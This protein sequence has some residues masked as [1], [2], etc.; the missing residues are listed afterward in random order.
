MSG[1]YPIWNEYPHNGLDRSPLY[2]IRPL[3]ANTHEVE[4]IISYFMRLANSHFLNLGTL[5]SKEIFPRL[6]RKYLTDSTIKGSSK[7]YDDAGLLLGSG[8]LAKDFVAILEHLTGTSLLHL[9]TLMNLKDAFSVRGMLKRTKAWC[10]VCYQ[11]WAYLGKDI[12]DPLIWSFQSST[13]CNKHHVPLQAVCE[14]CEC[15]PNHLSRQAKPGHCPR[16][17]RWL[18]KYVAPSKIPESQAWIVENVGEL[19][20]LSSDCSVDISRVKTIGFLT[21][22]IDCGFAGNIKRFADAM[23]LP[24]VTAWDWYRGHR[25]PEMKRVLNICYQLN[26]PLT[27]VFVSNNRTFNFQIEPRELVQTKQRVTRFRRFPHLL[28]EMFINIILEDERT[29]AFSMQQIANFLELNKRTLYQYYP[30]KCRVI[31]R[32][33]KT[34]LDRKRTEYINRLKSEVTETISS[35]TANGTRPTRRNIEAAAS[36]R[37]ILRS[38]E[39]R[40]FARQVLACPVRET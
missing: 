38:P 23:G 1:Q 11:E 5:L 14:F 34:F 39:M 35:L 2:Q 36:T 33:H 24:K 30:D 6:N 10:P 16:C 7:F 12:Y 40:D 20:T 28:V 29:R 32:R 21:E 31:S 22:I 19:L 17:H 26:Q 15:H 8:S 13:V 4:S 25:V 3:G 9:T 27:S 18:G 37:G